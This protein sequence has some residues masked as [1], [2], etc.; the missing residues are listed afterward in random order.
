M[1][2]YILLCTIKKEKVS[3]WEAIVSYNNK[4]VRASTHP[5]EYKNFKT[6][7]L[8]VSS[9][10]TSR[11]V[12][13]ERLFTTLELQQANCNT[14]IESTSCFRSPFRLS[15]HALQGRYTSGSSA[16]TA[17]NSAGTL[18]THFYMTD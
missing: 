18:S 13:Q 17:Q 3:E 14:A 4:T 1:M 9:K 16:G 15:L 12:V 5:Q 6:F 11:L 2:I 7:L 10:P 8:F